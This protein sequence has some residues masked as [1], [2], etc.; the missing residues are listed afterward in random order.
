MALLRRYLKLN[1]SVGLKNIGWGLVMGWPFMVLFV[2]E[3]PYVGEM[4]RDT[5]FRPMM[6]LMMVMA[7]LVAV[8]EEIIFRG[9]IEQLVQK[10][11]KGHAILTVMISAA[12]FALFHL[13]NISGATATWPDVIG[14]VLFAFG[15]GLLLGTVYLLTGNLLVVIVLHYLTDVVSIS[16]SV[17]VQSDFK[18]L[19]LKVDWS[20]YTSQYALIAGAI[21]LSILYGAIYKYHRHIADGGKT[22]A[23]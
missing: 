15:A 9:S 4:W 7:G 18:M 17:Y 10:T 22:D 20:Q 5:D 16:A 2:T 3:I 8:A 11:F 1:Y 13:T 23:G 6:V 21:A 19:G 14:T 12:I